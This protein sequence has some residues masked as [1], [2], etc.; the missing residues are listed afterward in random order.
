MKDTKVN[1]GKPLEV[2]S[3][4]HTKYIMCFSLQEAKNVKREKKQYFKSISNWFEIITL[5]LAIGAIIGYF[6]K[7]FMAM[8][9]MERLNETPNE[10]HSFQYLAYWD[11][12]S[13]QALFRI[14]I[15]SG[16]TDKSPTVNKF[17]EQRT[18]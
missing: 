10:F 17:R 14:V 11:D 18:I 8:R 16:E 9:L 5:G 15:I 3:N 7:L 12:V 2:D 6:Y 13:N 1:V 4:K